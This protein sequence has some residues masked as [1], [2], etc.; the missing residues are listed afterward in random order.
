MRGLL[1]LL[2][3]GCFSEVE[4][5]ACFS[6]GTTFLDE[7][8]AHARRSDPLIPWAAVTDVCC[9]DADPSAGAET[10][11]AWYRDHSGLDGELWQLAACAPGGYCQL[12][13]RAGA[14][15]A[16]VTARDC[17]GAACILVDRTEQDDRCA[18]QG[19]TGAEQRCTICA[20]GGA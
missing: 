12:D 3:V 19:Q 15:C 4:T 14:N 10:C 5:P 2:L 11:R 17:G 16:C 20:P 6:D 13:C 7:R 18:A 9:D 1:P 8:P